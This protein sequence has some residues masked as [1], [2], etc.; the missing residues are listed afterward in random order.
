[1]PKKELSAEGN[2]TQSRL[3]LSS[4]VVPCIYS[5]AR[6]NNTEMSHNTETFPVSYF[7]P[8]IVMRLKI[9]NPELLSKIKK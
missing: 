9:S 7:G 4:R 3:V 2:T 5:R 6:N 1:M 8:K